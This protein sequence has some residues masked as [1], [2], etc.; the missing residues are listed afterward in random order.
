MAAEG[1][2]MRA[3][4]AL[5]SLACIGGTALAQ[6]HPSASPGAA[7]APH[8]QAAGSTHALDRKGK[9]PARAKGAAAKRVQS[10][11]KASDALS[12]CLEIWE[13]ATHMTK[14]EWN[15]AC[16]RVAERLKNTKFQ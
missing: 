9:R 15:R 7:P 4:L 11:A 14:R 12:S 13:P 3:T 8:A 5:L 2:S 6:V 16:Q 10:A 1:K